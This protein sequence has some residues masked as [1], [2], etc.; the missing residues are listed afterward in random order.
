MLDNAAK[1]FSI[2]GELYVHVLWSTVECVSVRLLMPLI[3]EL[4]NVRAALLH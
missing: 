4:L 3:D 2:S 1:G